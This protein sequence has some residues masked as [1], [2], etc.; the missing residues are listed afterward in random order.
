MFN[1]RQLA[2]SVRIA[3]ESTCGEQAGW[4]P[5]N[6]ML[7]LCNKDDLQ[8]RPAC[9]SIPRD[10]LDMETLHLF[11]SLNTFMIH[12]ILDAMEKFD[13]GIENILAQTA[14]DSTFRSALGKILPQRPLDFFF[15]TNSFVQREW[16]LID[17]GCTRDQDLDQ[18]QFQEVNVGGSDTKLQ[19]DGTDWSRS[20]RAVSESPHHEIQFSRI[21]YSLSDIE[22]DIL[23]EIV[24]RDNSRSDPG[25]HENLMRFS[26]DTCE[27]VNDQQFD[28]IF[29]H[30]SSTS[31][32][33]FDEQ[34]CR[35][36]GV[37]RKQNS[38]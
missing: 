25:L 33:V 20:C 1:L 22:G 4:I 12:E 14:Y 10:D 26:F 2:L 15:S 27:G 35:S 19:E 11:P 37:K 28:D 18:I 38:R 36:N 8:T 23:E 9:G 6:Q 29:N 7:C 3:I 21:P 30:R 31:F 17:S 13:L 16:K 32:Q 5:S 24:C 34:N